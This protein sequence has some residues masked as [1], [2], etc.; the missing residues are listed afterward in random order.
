MDK[1][2]NIDISVTHI[3]HPEI[4]LYKIQA[5]AMVVVQFKKIKHTKTW[6][7]TTHK[8][9]LNT[10][11][12]N[13]TRESKSQRSVSKNTA[14]D[15]LQHNFL[16]YFAQCRNDGPLRRAMERE[17]MGRKGGNLIFNMYLELLCPQHPNTARYWFKELIS[18]YFKGMI[19]FIKIYYVFTFKQSRNINT[20]ITIVWE[21]N[22]Y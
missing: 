19:Q 11:R 5:A 22:N 9:G 14:Y 4:C 15:S 21:P 17:H 6:T 13:I 3:C 16:L 12:E 7:Y 18:C 8:L 2:R 1:F 10:A 20:G